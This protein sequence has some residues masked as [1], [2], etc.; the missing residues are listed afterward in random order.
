VQRN[1]LAPALLLALAL[2]AP[3]HAV[4]VAAVSPQGDVA[5]VRQVSVRFDGPVVPAGDPRLPPPFTLNCNGAVPA[6]DARWANDRVWL[7][8]LAVALPPGQRCTLSLAAGWKPQGGTALEGDTEF[9]FQTG[10]LAV[11]QVRPYA[12]ARIDEDQR[13]LLRFNGPADAAQASNAWCEVEGLG[14]R[15]PLHVIDGAEREAVLRAQRLTKDAA[16]WLLVACARPLAPDA[17]VRV[18]WGKRFEWKVRTRLLAEFTCEREKA[19]APCMPLRPMTVRFSAPVAR[20][21]A[22]GARLVPAQGQ[23]LQPQAGNDGADWVSEIRFAAPLPENQRLRLTLAA[24]IR[25]EAGRELAN[26]ASFP[27]EVATGPMPPL[28]KFAG[29]PFAIVEA[30]PEA[31]MPLTL[32][33]VQAD[34]QGATTGG[35]VRIKRLDPSASDGELMRWLSRLQKMQDERWE[36]REQTLLATEPGV[37]ASALPQLKGSAPAATEV[38]GVPLA[39]NG[40][41]VIEVESRILGDA[42]LAQRAPMYVRN[43]A[44]VTNLGVHFKRGRSSSLIW[45]TT[46]DRGRPVA[47][48]KVAVN[49][50]RGRVLWSGTSDANGIARIERGF[51]DAEADGDN[52]LARDGL[53]VSARVTGPGGSDL[54]FVFSGWQKG[55]ESWRFNLP[56]ARG[57]ESDRRAHTVFDR[58]LLRAGETVAMKHFV[59]DEVAAGLVFTPAAALPN[60]LVLT[61]VGSGAETTLPLAWPRG[62]RASESRWTIPQTAK[63]GVYDVALKQGDRRWPGGSFR[64]EAFRVPLVD[65]R[66]TAP[67]GPLIAPNDVALDVQLQMNAGGP[68]ARAPAKLSALLRPYAPEFDGYDEYSFRPP[69]RERPQRDDEDSSDDGARVVAER[70]PATTDAKGA[71][72]VVL[73]KLPLPPNAPAELVAELSFNDPNGEVQTASRRVVVWPSAFVVGVRAR[74]WAAPRGQAQ[75]SAVVLDTAGK[76]LAGKTVD[77]SGRLTTTLSSRKRIVGGFYAYD[78]K[79]QTREL[80]ALCTGRTDD[81]GRID[82]DAKFD[83]KTHGEVEL[84]ARAKDDAGRTAEAAATVWVSNGGELWFEQ[85]NDDRIDVLPEKR[86]LQPGET[87]RLQVR[88][89]FR[90]ATALV[91]VEREGVLDTRVITLRGTRPVVELPIPKGEKSWAPNAV[92]SVL[93]LRGRL[94]EAPWWSIFTWGW[95]EPAE[96]WR[97]FRYEDKDY[98]APTAMVDLAK[99][100]FKFGAAMLKIGLAEHRLDVKVTPEKPQYGVRETV[101]TRIK[102]TRAGQPVAGTEI[103]FAAVDE[104]LLALKPNDSWNA[105]EALFQP[106]P[107]GVE[108][109]TAQSEI[110]GRRHYGRKALPPGGGGG[111]NPTRELFDTLLLWRGT[112]ALDASGEAVIDVPLNDSLTS[113]RLVAIADAGPD[114]FGTGSASVRVS[115]DLQMLAGLPPLVREGDRFDAGFTLRNTTARAMNVKATLEGPVSGLAPQTVALA[116]GAAAEV[117]W[118]LEV[119]RGVTKL[120]WTGAAAEANGAAK[121]RVKIVQAVQPAV[122]V[123][124]WQASLQPLADNTSLPLAPPAD[125]LPGSGGI[126]VGLQPK[127]SGAL[128]GLKRFFETY[129]YSCIEQKTS[130]ALALHDAAAWNALKAELAGYLDRDGLAHYFPPRP[131]EAPGGSDRLTAY[132][133]SAAHEAGLA[134]PDAARDAMLQGLAAFVEGRIERRFWAPRADLD[135]RKLA[136]LDALSRHGRVLPRQLQSI[137]WTP[138][139]W[140]TAALL[141]AWGVYRRSEALPERAARLDELQRLLRSRLV[142]GGTT[143]RFTTEE[144]DNWWWLMDSAD[145]NAARLVLAAA[146]TPAW[147]DDVPLLV[148]GALARQRQGAWQTTTANLWGVLALERFSA[149]FEVTPVA[150]RTSFGTGPT[151]RTLDWKTQPDGTSELLPWGPAL[152]AKHEGAGRPW[153]SVQT[154]AAV[155]LKE[156]LAAGYRI[157][158]SVTAV[159]RA[160][161]D[162]WTR[163]DI[164]RVRLEV[165]AVGDMT[166]VVVSDPLPAGAAVLGGGLGRDSAIATRGERREGS[167]WIAFEERAADAWRG[168]YAF[169]PRGRHVVEYT[170]RLSASGRF[171][172][173]PTRVEAMYAPETFGERPNEPVEVKP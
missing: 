121:D 51:D 154:L 119:P 164:V 19:G 3:A 24:A 132:L 80:G 20:A 138:G 134:W 49:D 1:R 112:V 91:S 67:Q 158:R 38:I 68:L 148:N 130:K 40:L 147:K 61:H 72:R 127:L 58:T 57:I 74:S 90:E 137:Q 62:A 52:C 46:L 53:M 89:P 44:L 8:D 83:D 75:F 88:M 129:P 11:Q 99:P 161:D 133:V 78:N 153:L 10:A 131:D 143:L 33:H 109:S 43:A 116:A 4:R 106:R 16:A 172:L 39:A 159:E 73:P 117:K 56:T 140:P 28:A 22:L 9:R 101:R 87:A 145:A 96:W 136:A 92:V 118:S 139:T 34:L 171:A 95:R 6:G 79:R 37:S 85:D 15:L 102:V 17:R 55:I 70:L 108:T 82:C 165:E 97:A 23:P 142:Q 167:A 114:R 45:V 107:W 163:G 128:P 152:N 156:P 36:S 120:E 18:V 76:P 14:E 115:Q 59:R 86:E 65:A 25:D 7:Y 135:V 105:L 168:Y 122:P 124:V 69:G 169:M 170:L 104:G 98:R 93:V 149:R 50:C 32:R 35:Q 144:T 21:A 125:A 84:V 160:K 41:H 81:Q 162:G 157:T 150:G 2:A 77:V 5:A 66:L 42:L 13:F 29:A 110:V 173:P 71:A 30:G 60:E 123:R 27:L 48:A 166:W 54:A 126:R 111:R 64:V 26:A 31:M 113:F 94:R 100:S 155:P 63:L 103:A 12:G 141:D 47:G 151:T 146:D